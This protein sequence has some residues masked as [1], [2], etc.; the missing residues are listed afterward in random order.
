MIWYNEPLNLE[1]QPNDISISLVGGYN[2]TKYSIYKL[3]ILFIIT[4]AS[5]K[6]QSHVIEVQNPTSLCYED[7]PKEDIYSKYQNK[8]AKIMSSATSRDYPG[9]LIWLKS[10]SLFNRGRSQTY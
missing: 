3:C 9:F 2:E 10:R 4:D 7:P 5:G 1:G 6:G 8:M